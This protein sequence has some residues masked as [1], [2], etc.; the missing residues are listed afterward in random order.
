M[1]EKAQYE[2]S[3]EVAVQGALEAIY[4]PLENRERVEFK[5]DGV[6]VSVFDADK[7]QIE[8]SCKI[9]EALIVGRDLGGSD[10][11]RT[12]PQGIVDYI[13]AAFKD[14]SEVK[15]QVISDQELLE[16][17]YPCFGAVNRATRNVPRHH[18]RVVIF[19]YR[20]GTPEE[21]I[22]LVGKGVTY[23]TGGADIKAGGVMAGRYVRVG[24][25]DAEGRMAMVDVQK[26][27]DFRKKMI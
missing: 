1:A 22:C 11:E 12:A 16:R 17:E 3:L 27:G 25:T 14:L 20:N 9:E 19:E 15:Y 10:P 26:R 18:G 8:K 23:D 13:H 7:A 6:S 5:R 4:M 2:E 21:H 24:N